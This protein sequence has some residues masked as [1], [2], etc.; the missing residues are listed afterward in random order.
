MEGRGEERASFPFDSDVVLI[1]AG[2][3]DNHK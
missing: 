1:E 2:S 3:A